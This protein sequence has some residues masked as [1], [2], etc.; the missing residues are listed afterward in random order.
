MQRPGRA[1]GHLIVLKHRRAIYDHVTDAQRKLVRLV[2]CRL[3]DDRVLVEDHD[4]SREAFAN[5]SAIAKP[6]RLRRQRSHLSDRIFERDQFQL[7]NVAS[8]HARVVAV[9][10]RMRNAVVNLS[11]AASDAIIVNGSCMIRFTS[12]SPML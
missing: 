11:H 12:S 4:V 2:E 10:T 6:K 5:Q 7:A 9:S 1:L 3:I 8:E